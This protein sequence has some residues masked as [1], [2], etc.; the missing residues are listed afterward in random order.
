MDDV[1]EREGSITWTRDVFVFAVMVGW[2]SGKVALKE[3][4]KLT[5]LLTN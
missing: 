5:Y 1:G 3:N 2:S 4:M